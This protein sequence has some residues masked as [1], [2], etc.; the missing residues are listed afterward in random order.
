M[1]TVRTAEGAQRETRAPARYARLR[2]RLLCQGVVPTVPL[3]RVQKRGDLGL[4]G[5]GDAARAAED[6]CHVDHA[7]AVGEE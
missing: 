5:S 3:G 7:L 4:P 6:G 1:V 2:I